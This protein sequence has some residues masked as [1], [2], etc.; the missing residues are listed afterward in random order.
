MIPLDDRNVL[1]SFFPV[2]EIRIPLNWVIRVQEQ[3]IFYFELFT[4]ALVRTEVLYICVLE[5]ITY[6][7]G[8]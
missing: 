3:G 2:F 5:P 4:I 8:T 7:Y 6:R 1:A